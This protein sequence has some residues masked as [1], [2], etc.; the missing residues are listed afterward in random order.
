ME[1]GTSANENSN[2]LSSIE[3]NIF[4]FNYNSNY[5]SNVITSEFN[6]NNEI[7]NI[8]A[9]NNKQSSRTVY[10]PIHGHL[11][12]DDYVWKIIDTPEFQRLRNLKQL[13]S[14]QYVFPGGTHSRFEHS[15]GTAYLSNR[16][17]NHLIRN[18]ENKEEIGY[19]NYS[20]FHAQNEKINEEFNIRAVTMAGLCHDLGHGPFSHLF[21]R[22][23]IKTLE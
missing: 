12:F 10:D 1:N 2:A 8:N 5:N 6:N 7:F 13:G 20:Q 11:T 23:V 21:D 14:V 9:K 15:I 17:I 18:F 4:S 22:R 16:L 3:S 19:S